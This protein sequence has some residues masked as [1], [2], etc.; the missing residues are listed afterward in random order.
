M[1][2]ARY[3]IIVQSEWSG[4]RADALIALHARRSADSVARFHD[5]GGPSPLAVVLTGTDLYKDLPESR[6]A[7]ASLDRADRI[8][9]LQDDALRLLSA[10]WRR[11]CDVIFQSARAL[12][13]RAKARGRLD[14][15]VVGHLRAEK[16]PL[17]LFGAL[18]LVPRDLPISI[19]HIGSPL[20]ATLGRAAR[21]LQAE[22]PRYRYS[23]ALPRGLA[24][25]AMASAHVLIHPSVV[26]GGANVVVEAVTGG[27]PVIASRISGN[28][29]MLGP[30]YPGY[31]E[32]RDES[33]LASRLVQA[34]DDPRYLRAL[35][36]AAAA[37]KALFAPAAEAR[38]IR[39]LV[40]ILLAQG[41]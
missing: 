14:C 7:A 37:R 4:E 35:E 25:A 8:V 33:G 18:R 17:T 15:V 27:T 29:G 41:R 9:V 1:L 34:T 16:D 22:D 13:R 26:E 20:D 38:A 3:R 2:R 32:P 36:S 24:R 23:G 21:E 10:A 40:E 12:P 28:I 39:R 5:R 6:E 30:A 11:K 19:R 31:F